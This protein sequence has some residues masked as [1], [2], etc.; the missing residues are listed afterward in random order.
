MRSEIL[1][2]LGAILA[3]GFLG[4]GVRIGPAQNDTSR[5]S[6]VMVVPDITIQTKDYAEAR[7]S[8]RTKLVQQGPA[9]HQED[10]KN[11]T[12]PVGV[13]ELNF[14]SGRLHLRA[15]LNSPRAENKKYP[16]VLFLHG[17]FCFDVSDWNETKPFRDAGFV[18]MIPN[19]RGENRQPGN[20]SM[21]YDE[22]D[23]V[24]GA[25]EYLRK[26]P[27]I[28]DAR[29]Y[30]AGASTG[31][32]L[33]MLAALTYPHFRAAAS[34]SGSP[35]AVGY[36]RHAVAIGNSRDIPF[37]YRDAKELQLRSARVYAASFKCPARLY[38][39][40]EETHFALSTQPTADLAKQH[41]LDVQAIAVE[42]GH[43]SAEGAEI[44]MAITFFREA[45]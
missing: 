2:G 7:K 15:W 43:T 16:A 23:D 3:V 34:F 13:T 35:D 11:S 45:K 20:F 21:F 39:G 19:R 17:G 38:Y 40:T 41:G 33:T 37:D 12:P 24:I 22:V 26:Q 28:D 42:G 1:S 9:P 6:D 27:Y 25:A 31:G 18:V 32:T 10:C 29:I 36:T 8:F 44:A 4:V 30:V 14:P 5:K